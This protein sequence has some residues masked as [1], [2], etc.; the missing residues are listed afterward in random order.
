MTPLLDVNLLLA[1]AWPNHVHHELAHQWFR[2]VH[3]SGWATCPLT[4]S[5]FV[6]VSCNRMVL[7]EAATPSDAVQLLREL[8]QLPGHVFWSD[9]ISIAASDVF[10]LEHLIGHRQ[11]TDAHLLA[12]A[13]SH[14]GRLATLD[15][16]IQALIPKRS[17]VEDVLLV[18]QNSV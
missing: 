13:I 6:R 12:L 8:V 16:K 7:P 11:V 15:R 3:T 17:G 4:Q 1:L 10:P 5:G 2:S 14:E 18:V 9:E